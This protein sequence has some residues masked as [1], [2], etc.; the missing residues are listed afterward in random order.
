M[1]DIWGWVLLVVVLVNSF[2]QWVWWRHTYLAVRRSAGPFCASCG[3]PV[4]EDMLVVTDTLTA[5]LDR[6]PIPVHY[7]I[8]QRCGEPIASMPDEVEEPVE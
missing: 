4:G 3:G 6:P 5:M 2:L 7:F 1:G 8:C